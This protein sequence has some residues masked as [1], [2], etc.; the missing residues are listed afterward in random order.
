MSYFSTCFRKKRNI[1]HGT[2]NILKRTPLLLCY[3]DTHI[4][5]TEDIQWLSLGFYSGPG[6]VRNTV[7]QSA[8]VTR[9]NS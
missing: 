3:R 7:E 5:P 8:T 1:L 9:Y 6:H 2:N 4:L